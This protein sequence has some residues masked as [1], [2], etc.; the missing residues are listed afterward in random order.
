MLGVKTNP[1]LFFERKS[2]IFSVKEYKVCHSL[3]YDYDADDVGISIETFRKLPYPK[4]V[5]TRENHDAG[6]SVETLRSLPR[7]EIPHTGEDEGS[8]GEDLITL[9]GLKFRVGRFVP[10]GYQP[11]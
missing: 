2:Y 5:Q 9:P 7:K 10:P 6:I 1:Y 8:P 4:N 11:E 3:N